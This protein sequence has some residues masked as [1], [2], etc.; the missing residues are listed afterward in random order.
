MI[1]PNQTFSSFKLLS[2]PETEPDPL[3]ATPE[4]NRP[5][6]ERSPA[7]SAPGASAQSEPG[8]WEAE[9]RH[10]LLPGE[11]NPSLPSIQSCGSAVRHSLCVAVRGGSDLPH[12]AAGVC[13]KLI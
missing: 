3:S 4:Q 5:D 1:F 6:P 2:D 12:I 8:E 10:W 11:P 7:G 13:G 9:S